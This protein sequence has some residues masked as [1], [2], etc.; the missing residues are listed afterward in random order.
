MGGT[1]PH[2]LVLLDCS[3]QATS[4]PALG[5]TDLVV[6]GCG[7]LYLQRSESTGTALFLIDSKFLKLNG[8]APFFK[9]VF[10]CGPFFEVARKNHLL[11]WLFMEPDITSPV[12][13]CPG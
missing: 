7:Q 12:V 11:F 6:E 1:G 5:P 9:S 4:S 10:K 3:V 8:I 13:P 2:P